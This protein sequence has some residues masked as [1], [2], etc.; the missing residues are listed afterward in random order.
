MKAKNVTMIIKKIT[1]I[2]SL[3]VDFTSH[4]PLNIYIHLAIYGY[5]GK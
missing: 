2:K 5:A 1:S 3:T 4:T